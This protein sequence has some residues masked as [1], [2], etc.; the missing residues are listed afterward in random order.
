MISEDF[1]FE[2]EAHEQHEAWL[3]RSKVTLSM[4]SATP[5]PSAIAIKFER[6][7]QR[8][9]QPLVEKTDLHY[10]GWNLCTTLL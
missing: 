2:K 5:M 7:F 10:K 9:N 8:R 3:P 1:G 4:S 6:R